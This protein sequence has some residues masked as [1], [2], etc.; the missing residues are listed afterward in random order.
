MPTHK[1][2]SKYATIGNDV[3]QTNK[4]SLKAKGLLAYLISKPEGWQF[5]ARRMALELKEGRESILSGLAEL[6]TAGLLRREKTANGRVFYHVYSS[7][8]LQKT[9][10]SGNPTVGFSH[11][12]KTRPINKK[13]NINRWYKRF[14]QGKDTLIAVRM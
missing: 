2:Y 5:S 7:Y 4:I 3:L 11:R 13:D 6:E 12:G 8:E 1:V 10:E 14:Y 9:P